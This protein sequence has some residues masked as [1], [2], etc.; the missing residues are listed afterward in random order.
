[1]VHSE[2]DAGCV[3][4]AALS[5]LAGDHA[6]SVGRA[7]HVLTTRE[8]RRDHLGRRL[9]VGPLPGGPR[10]P[11]QRFARAHVVRPL[12]R[13]RLLLHRPRL[14]APRAGDAG[15]FRRRGAA[16]STSRCA[17]PAAGNVDSSLGQFLAHHLRS[18]QLA[19]R[20]SVPEA[21][22][23]HGFAMHFLQDAFAA[24]HLVMTEET[25]RSGNAKARRRHD[26]FNAKG[27]AVGRA[28][29]VEPCPDLGAGALELTGL[30]PCWVTSGDGL[31]R[32]VARR[33]G[34]ASRGARRHPRG[35]RAR[36]RPRSA[37]GRG[38][39]RGVRGAGSSSPWGTSSSRLPGGPWARTTAARLHAS[40]ARTLRL[41]RAAAAAI[42]R[43]RSAP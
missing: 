20:G 32:H 35:A 16:A 33:V 41:V 36:A 39:R 5:A 26:F 15:A 22:L 9:R 1:M 8:G 6:S 27:L 3:P 23:E 2:L 12:A 19:A 7:P 17:W 28:M 42:D 21:L 14:R 13:R 25:W 29:G 11:A 18:L 30:T 10:A 24:G 40:A 43:L 37:A 34:P 31:P 38:G 4:Y